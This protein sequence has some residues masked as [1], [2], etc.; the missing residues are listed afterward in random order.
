MRKTTLILAA[1]LSLSS[2]A[3]AGDGPATDA[4]P[5]PAPMPTVAPAP[6]A[7]PYSLPFQLRPIAQP[8]V[9]RLETALGWHGVD[10]SGSA[11]TNDV[12]ILTA[13]YAVTKGTGF[14]LRIPFVYNAPSGDGAPA[15]IFQIAN[16]AASVTHTPFPSDPVRV[17]FSAAL[18]VPVGNGHGTPPSAAAKAAN[19]SSQLTRLAMDNALF[20]PNDLALATGLSCAY[21]ENGLTLQADLTM[22]NTFKSR[23]ANGDAARTNGL[24]ALGA[25]YFFL[26][27]VS[28]NVEVLYQHWLTTPEAVAID[29]ARRSNLSALVGARYHHKFAWGW[30]RPG[31]ALAQG[32]DGF[33]KETTEVRVD[34]PFL[35]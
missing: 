1:S 12:T 21:V 28:A 30:A 18:S 35:F 34:L 13:G 32:L 22:L 8:T 20:L 24:A 11:G 17:S 26:P 4:L 15:S 31:V 16:L 2:L 9:L 23:E 7:N 27:E 25:G 33:T 3:A 19:A 14:G 29:A 10:P 6:A 5:S